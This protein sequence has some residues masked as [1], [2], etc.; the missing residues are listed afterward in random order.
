M[1]ERN[2]PSIFADRIFNEHFMASIFWAPVHNRLYAECS[3]AWPWRGR[4]GRGHREPLYP[5]DRRNTPLVDAD[6]AD[7][8]RCRDPDPHRAEWWWPVNFA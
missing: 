3:K 7:T 1:H 6:Q 5:Q 8:Q 4:A 2:D